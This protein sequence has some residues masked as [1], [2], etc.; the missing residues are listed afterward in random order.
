MI[1][2][3]SEENSKLREKKKFIT[4][5][6]ILA[7]KYRLNTAMELDNPMKTHV[8]QVFIGPDKRENNEKITRK[9]DLMLFFHLVKKSSFFLIIL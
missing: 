3:K 5:L 2:P 4:F 8:P 9:S 7:A 6:D 1:K